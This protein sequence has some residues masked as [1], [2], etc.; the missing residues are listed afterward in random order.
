MDAYACPNAD[1]RHVGTSMALSSTEHVVKVNA[2]IKENHLDAV[3]SWN[4]NKKGKKKCP[5]MGQLVDQQIG[6]YYFLLFCRF[7]A[8][9]D[10]CP[11]CKN[12]R[13]GRYQVRDGDG[14]PHCTCDIC[15]CD[16]S[17]VSN[18][19]E[20]HKLTAKNLQEKQQRQMRDGDIKR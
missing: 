13:A 4:R 19:N 12:G 17:Y 1:C 15:N 14:K 8:D 10:N 7:L 9:G 5:S 2:E 18:R 20:R 6:C 11:N 3:T 16:C